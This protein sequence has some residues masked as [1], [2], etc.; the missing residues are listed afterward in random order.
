MKI[1]EWL[2]GIIVIATLMGSWAAWV[3]E[4]DRHID[5]IMECLHRHNMTA[6]EQAVIACEQELHK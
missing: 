1:I 5:A 6:H 4:N 2:A 3:S